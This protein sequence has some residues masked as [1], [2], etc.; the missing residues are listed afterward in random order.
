MGSIPPGPGSDPADTTGVP[1]P[2]MPPI[3]DIVADFE[4]VVPAGTPSSLG[5]QFSSLQGAGGGY[6]KN[7]VVVDTENCNFTE[8]PMDPI[9]R[10]SVSYWIMLEES[11]EP[12]PRMRW[13]RQGGY[14]GSEEYVEQNQKILSITY[15]A[16]ANQTT[17]SEQHPYGRRIENLRLNFKDF[18]EEEGYGMEPFLE[19]LRSMGYATTGREYLD[20]AL[21]YQEAYSAKE[22][23]IIYD[24]AAP[25][26]Q[27]TADVKFDYNFYTKL[28]E[29]NLDRYSIPETLTP[30]IY[31]LYLEKERGLTGG[32][33]SFYGDETDIGFQEPRINQS[34]YLNQWVY[35]DFITLNRSSELQ[36]IFINSIRETSAGSDKRGEVDRGEYYDIWASRYEFATAGSVETSAGTTDL[37]TGIGILSEKYRNILIP[38][39]TEEKIHTSFNTYKELFPIFS[40]VRYSQTL[41]NQVVR[42]VTADP[43]NLAILNNLLRDVFV[44][45]NNFTDPVLEQQFSAYRKFAENHERLYRDPASGPITLPVGGTATRKIFNVGNWALGEEFV[46]LPYSPNEVDTNYLF[47]QNFAGERLESTLSDLMMIVRNPDFIDDTP[48]GLSGICASTRDILLN[49]CNNHRRTYKDIISGDRAYS[50]DV[51]FKVSKFYVSPEGVKSILP[52]Q[53]FYLINDAHNRRVVNLIDTQLKYGRTYEYEISTLRLVV[54]TKT[55]ILEAKYFNPESFTI[56]DDGE[57]GF[58]VVGQFEPVTMGEVSF[59]GD[60]PVIEESV[61]E[62]LTPTGFLSDGEQ[63]YLVDVEVELTPSIQIIELPYVSS[64]SSGL[65]V[66]RGTVLDDPPMPPEVQAFSYRG[67]NSQLLFLLNT[68]AGSKEFEPIVFSPQ[69]QMYVNRL[70]SMN[71]DPNKLTILYENDDPSTQF[72]IYRTEKKP[73][74]YD[75]FKGNLLSLVDTRDELIGYRNASSTSFKNKVVPNTKYYYMFRAIDIHGHYSYPSPVYEIELIDND[76]AV[77][78]LINIVQLD[79]IPRRTT[80]IKKLNR[81]LKI[82]PAFLQSV[83]DSTSSEL[84]SDLNAPTN[85]DLPIGVQD[86]SVWDKTYKIRLTSRKTGRKIDLNIKCK[87]EYEPTRPPDM[88]PLS[89]AGTSVPT[90]TTPSSPSEVIEYT[91]ADLPSSLTTPAKGELPLAEAPTLVTELAKDAG[92]G[93]PKAAPPAG[94]VPKA[95]GPSPDLPTI[96]ATAP[97]GGKPSATAVPTILEDASG[98]AAT[99]LVP[100]VDGSKAGTSGPTEAIAVPAAVP[101]AAGNKPASTPAAATAAAPG[102]A[103]FEE[104]APAAATPPPAAAAAPA[105]APAPAPAAAAAPA[106]A[107][108]AAPAPAPAPAAAAAPAPAPSPP[109]LAEASPGPA[110]TTARNK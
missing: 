46:N 69:E 42:A 79:P 11:D 58:R 28:Y 8:V 98:K 78:P 45:F 70:K 1:T 95:P 21:E 2:E 37:G 67:D 94:G 108:A 39:T 63:I 27:L 72:E 38:L 12:N 62:P 50:E 33:S 49:L 16:A 71:L 35:N 48:A 41:P 56:R 7:A 87:K 10:G 59:V 104:A 52:M 85:S 74:T 31:T 103:P 44:D 64:T 6:A 81:F 55:R 15:Q 54:G 40:E 18:F 32:D 105:P 20:H 106:P 97:G 107:P 75:D 61:G 77:Y 99:L 91:A 17:P 65:T 101:T 82:G 102:P 96:I 9:R 22:N 36:R 93:L 76:G 89:I 83:L 13:A 80:R 5:R 47:L 23:Q 66:M 30:H 19:Y 34:G 24:G 3:E 25:A 109:P 43:N 53:S 84:Q 57:P 4:E 92:D 100:S 88:P 29:E 68:G 26:E 60:A 51:F 73:R 14:E 90:T 86:I 110:A